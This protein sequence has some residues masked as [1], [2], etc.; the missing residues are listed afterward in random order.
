MY[1]LASGWQTLTGPTGNKVLP[2]G[3][4]VDNVLTTAA[5]NHHLFGACDAFTKPFKIFRDG[6]S[7]L[8][9]RTAGLPKLASSPAISVAAGANVYRWRFLHKVQYTVGTVT[10]L[11]RG[12]T[13]E[14]VKTSVAA[15]GSASITAIPVLANG[16]TDNYDTTNLKVE[17]YRTVAN[18]SVFYRV[19]EVANGTTTYTD[20]TAD[21]TLQLNERLYTEG[22]VV[23]NDA[24]PLAKLVHVC[25]DVGLYACIKEGSETRLNRVM[26]SIPGD[27]DS[28][29]ATFYLDVDDDIIGLS[30]VRGV[31]I[32]LCTR[33]VYRIDG[34]FDELGRGGMIAQRI[35][36]TASCAG[37]SSAVQTLE[38]VH[39]CGEDATYFTD[40]AR[41]IA[42]NDD[43]P[44]TYAKYTGTAEQRRRMQGAYDRV[45]RRV[46][47]TAQEGVDCD[48]CIVLDTNWGLGE[49]MPFT[50]QGN[51]SASFAPSAIAFD[52]LGQLVRG[53]KRGY[54]FQ[55]RAVYLNDPMVDLTL[56]TTAWDLETI[57]YKY[58]SCAFNFGSNFERKYIPRISLQ[59]KNATNLSLGIFSNNDD[60]KSE[61]E[62]KP[63]RFRANIIWNITDV[64][65]GDPDYIWNYSG[66]IEEWRRFP[67]RNL[68]C[69][70]KSVR[71]ENGFVVIGT[72]DIRCPANV[73][74]TAKTATLADTVNFD[75]LGYM[76]DQYI[77][78]SSN[79]DREYRI[80]SFTPD[81]ITYED[82][83]GFSVTASGV[84]WEI[85]GYPKDEIFHLI[86]FTLHFAQFGK[87]Q[88]HFTKAEAGSIAG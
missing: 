56:A 25:E 38:G 40:G 49:K 30:S 20:T 86:S 27:I 85:R 65:W 28:V 78:F 31:P 75:W 77:A 67:A 73:D 21:A 22:G 87:T 33:S 7:V 43:W 17:I 74:A 3:V 9:V 11:D 1:Y 81:V 84:E 23:E 32:L 51:G 83:G 79:W 12:A 48:T 8:Q 41:V 54:L 68:R 42:T 35:S 18:G 4:T 19:A 80:L 70:Y 36:D 88:D 29:P 5:W 47:W 72:S 14:V 34:R 26:Q 57:R 58:E 59:A 44:T 60:G 15:I 64:T 63:I 69:S 66:F 52:S 13:T 76:R 39:W 10:F 46:W 82:A 16:A 53:D 45:N 6:S 61:A 37:S 55:H 2:S 24:P 62:L 71:L 50:L